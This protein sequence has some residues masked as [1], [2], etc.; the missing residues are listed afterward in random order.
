MKKGFGAGKVI[1]LGEHSV[2]YG[3][4]AIAAGLSTGVW[5][6]AAESEAWSLSAPQWDLKSDLQGD[7]L[8]DEA[9]RQII[10][11][12]SKSVSELAPVRFAVES[13]LPTGAG[14]G[15]SAALAVALVRALLSESGQQPNRSLVLEAA[16]ASEMVFHGRA[17]GI[18]HTTSAHGGLL[19]FQ[20]SPEPTFTTIPCPETLH[21]VVAQVQAGASTAQM[22]SGVRERYEGST[23]ARAQVLQLGEF[24][25][26][27]EEALKTG[28]LA[29]L[30]EQMTQAHGVLADLGVSTD[31]LNRAQTRALAAG[32]LGA[33]LTGSGGGGCVIAL[34]SED[35][36]EAVYHALAED[37]MLAFRTTVRSDL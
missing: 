8:L 13:N 33:K 15:S 10:Q 5:V 12:V 26:A 22:V 11:T 1:L 19:R 9:L 4:P 14:L 6:E 29:G 27:G 32:A 7:S 16:M 20:R 34:A 24:A 2:V 30:G 3:E 17:S 21:L 31:P 23:E 36:V 25:K 37:A 18:D 28:D 35:Q